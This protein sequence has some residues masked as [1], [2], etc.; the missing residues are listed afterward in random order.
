MD[1]RAGPG[2]RRFALDNEQIAAFRRVEAACLRISREHPAEARRIEARA[3]ALSYGVDVAEGDRQALARVSQDY[4]HTEAGAEAAY[5]LGASYWQAG[6]FFS[7]A[8]CWQR[9]AESG[10]RARRFEPALSLQLAACW[11]AVGEPQRIPPRLAQLKSQYAGAPLDVAGQPEQWFDDTDDALSWLVDL[12]G[13]EPTSIEAQWGVF[14]GRPSRNPVAQGGSPYLVAEPLGEPE[15]ASL[16][17]KAVDRVREEYFGRRRAALPAMYPLVADD[18]LVVRTATRLRA[19]HVESGELLWEA[20]P[21]DP[22]AD[23][24]ASPGAEND[25]MLAELLPND[26]LHRLWQNLAYTATSSDGRFVYAVEGL[27]L[28][29][30]IGPQRLVVNR[31]G[32]RRLDAGALEN[33]NLLAAYDLAT[34]KLC[35]EVGGPAG[36]EGRALAGAYFLGPPLPLGAGLYCVAEVGDQTV[37]LVLDAATGALQWQRVLT[38]REEPSLPQRVIQVLGFSMPQ[39]Q[40]PARATGASPSY[41]DGILVCPIDDERIVALDLTSRSVIWLYEGQDDLEGETLAQ[42]RM[43]LMQAQTQSPRPPT[44]R[45]VDPYVVIVDGYILLTPANGDKLVCLRLVDGMEQWTAPRGDGL[46]LG[47]VH[48]GVVVVVGRSSVRGF[49]LADGRPAWDDLPLPPGALPSGR[50]FLSGER[51]YIPL[52]TAEVLGVDVPA[53]RVASRSRSPEGIVPG[54]LVGLSDGVVSQSA[55]GLW[56]FDLIA[57][58]ERQAARRIEENPDDAAAWAER[59]ELL[60]CDGRIAEA[61]ECLSKA[62]QLEPAAQ[63]QRQLARAVTDG[64]WAD[65]PRFRPLAESLE[66]DAMEAGQRASVLRAM[67]WGAQHAGDVATAFDRFLQLVE[68]DPAADVMESLSAAVR[69]RRDRWLAARLEELLD[70]A[71]DEV[72]AQVEPRLASFSDELRVR[73]LPFQPP[74]I[75]VWLRTGA[76]LAEEGEKLTAELRLRTAL[77]L[78]QPEARPEAVARLAE[79]LRREGRPRAAARLYAK[80]A[81]PLADAV[82][83]EGRT[84]REVVAAL[85]ADDPARPEHVAAPL[86]PSDKLKAEAKTHDGRQSV[87]AHA[88]VRVRPVDPRF[89]R[90]ADIRVENVGQALYG[91]DELGRQTWELSLEDVQPRFGFRNGY[92]LAE[93]A[94]L[95]DIVVVWLVSRV[96]ALDISGEKPRLLWEHATT[97]LGSN[98]PQYRHRMQLAQKRRMQQQQAG[99]SVGESSPLVVAHGYACFQRNEELVAVDLERGELLWARDDVAENVDL[100]GDA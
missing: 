77:W 83:L 88:P 80:L 13:H 20:Q 63:S 33:D 53:G 81:G 59:G 19:F 76:E 97:D 67:G 29:G 11:L 3:R 43:R 15:K 55:A 47:G 14:R 1:L 28:H 12:L 42:R 66:L 30:L 40:Q 70:G 24:L 37:L 100:F 5:L 18:A 48:E 86:W 62:R 46:Y 68:I 79:L 69:V 31:D 85:A 92:Y 41:A 60:L 2:A 54:N 89:D 4:F 93:G 7:A 8:A 96:V 75:D 10:D 49:R 57:D 16:L 56:R 34:G 91:Y 73:Y 84:G 87:V 98:D 22:L 45:W 52:S 27:S 38:V 74:T 36:S 23:L 90:P 35:W 6:Q 9:L 64:L 61:V 26:L 25:G 21:D 65:Y 78:T 50:G 39:V 94:Q 99:G 32:S 17:R 58:R 95:G 51:L 44:D 72:R 71:T 82:V